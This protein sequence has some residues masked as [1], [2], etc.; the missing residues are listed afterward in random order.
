MNRTYDFATIG[1]RPYTETEEFVTIGVV[2]LDT[3]ARHFGFVLQGGRKTGR[4]QGMFPA[5]E[6]ALYQEA[7][8]KLKAELEGIEIAINGQAG[9]ANVPIF[10]AFRENDKG[11]FASITSPR[12]GI[13]C[14]PVRGRRM[15][16]SMEDVLQVLKE[17]FIDQTPL[18]AQ[19]AGEQ[20]MTKELK[21][22][23]RAAKI[24][25]AYKTNVKIG[26][27]EFM[28]T[29][30]LAHL[31]GGNTADRALRPLNFDLATSTDI[32]NHGDEWIQKLR[33]LKR[34]GFRPDR[35]LIA[36]R[37]PV[38]PLETDGLRMNAFRQIQEELLR[39]DIEL[40]G[41]FDA[42]KV[43]AFARLPEAPVLKLA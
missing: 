18:T 27:D 39:E 2:A 34:L 6:R 38:G 8:R 41:E 16:A 35:C 7:R 40:A 13:F 22:V 23:L 11:L 17:R 28:V 29:F 42:D 30:A 31:T 32:F 15:A 9:G 36:A 26:P 12:E 20:E 21:K 14:Y 33:R 5:V 1:F 37:E 24:L 3:A 4:I 43:I 19:Q 10:H 25:P